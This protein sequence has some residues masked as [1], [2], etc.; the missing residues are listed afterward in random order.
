MDLASSKRVVQLRCCDWPELTDSDHE[1]GSLDAGCVLLSQRL[2]AVCRVKH[3][4]ESR[5]THLCRAARSW[6]RLRSSGGARA[7]WSARCW[8]VSSLSARSWSDWNTLLRASR[9]GPCAHMFA[10]VIVASRSSK[11]GQ[12]IHLSNWQQ[13]SPIGVRGRAAI[14]QLPGLQSTM[15][16]RTC[17]AVQFKSLDSML[18]VSVQNAICAGCN[19]SSYL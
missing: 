17:Q 14:M 7:F 1:M 18:S 19:Q 10:S 13:T 16:K 9:A 3:E 6:S 5:A 11:R 8:N 12:Q 15:M 4:R 2:W